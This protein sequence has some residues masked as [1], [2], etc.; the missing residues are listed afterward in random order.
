MSNGKRKNIDDF[1]AKIKSKQANKL[2]VDVLFQSVQQNDKTALSKA[3]TLVESQ[4]S[5]D[6]ETAHA[7]LEKCLPEKSNTQ[8][9]AITGI[10]GVGKSTFINA[11]AKHLSEQGKKVAVLSVDPSSSISQGSILGD[12]TRMDDLAELPNV[13]IR[14][15][16]TGNTLGGVHLRTRE[17]MLLCE[18]AGYD[19]IIIETVGV[20]QSEHEVKNMTDIMVVMLLPGSGD[21]LQGIKKGIMETADIVLINKADLFPEQ[22]INHTLADYKKAMHLQAE[23]SNKWI[24]QILPA[25]AFEIEKLEKVSATIQQYFNHN[26]LNG[27]FK[28]NRKAQWQLWFK[29]SIGWATQEAL[30][31]KGIDVE[32]N[33]VD[34][35]ELPPAKALRLIKNA[36]R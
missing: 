19:T 36:L 13:Y 17:V 20:G 11:Y 18:A 22:N 25:S 2:D 14:P 28:Q 4:K 33:E 1:I 9:I 5:E 29:K 6:I 24:P 32:N 16:A 34:S 8:R 7:L 23:K 31:S 3:I 27:S 26:L 12:K 35:D 21:S 10:P 15:T 30:K